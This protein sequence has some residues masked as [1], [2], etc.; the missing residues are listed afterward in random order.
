MRGGARADPRIPDAGSLPLARF[1]VAEGE[2]AL[3]APLPSNTP[4]GMARG[5][6]GRVLDPIVFLP[7]TGARSRDLPA[8][9]GHG[10]AG[11]RQFRRWTASGLWQVMREAS[12][13]GGGEADLP[14]MMH[15]SS[16]RAHHRPAGEGAP[17]STGACALA[18]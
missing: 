6:N 10:D 17:S 14:Q 7:R 5:D 1:A 15:G 8:A 16:I 18:R 9:R 4:R 3:I 12:A 2:W 13:D 11:L